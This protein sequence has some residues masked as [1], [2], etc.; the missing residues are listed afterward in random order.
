M[1]SNAGC[2]ETKFKR[3][4]LWNV[5][6]GDQSKKKWLNKSKKM[7]QWHTRIWKYDS[8]Y[9]KTVIRVRSNE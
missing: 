8:K 1:E 7:K 5:S 6:C 4:K 3:C 2:N 9:I